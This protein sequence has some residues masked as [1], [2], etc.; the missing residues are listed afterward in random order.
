M[1][2][3]RRGRWGISLTLLALGIIAWFTLRPSPEDA[4]AA[5]RSSFTCLFP[6]GNESLRDIILNIILFVPFGLGLGLW[7][8]ALRAWLLSVLT[9]CTIE[10]VQYGWLLGRDASLRD[11]L[12]NS[13][14]GAIGVA[15]VSHWEGLLLPDLARSRRLAAAAFALWAVTTAAGAVLIRPVL[16]RSVY[17]GQWAPELGQFDRWQGT[18]REVEVGGVG[19]P[20]GRMTES[21]AFRERLLVDSVLVEATVITGPAPA[22]FAPIAS[23]FDSEQRE[24]FVLGQ[25]GRDLAFRIRTGFSAIELRGQIA[26]MREAFSGEPGDTIEVRGG[27]VNGEWVLGTRD[28]RGDREVRLPFSA[29]LAWSGLLP[30]PVPLDEQ[31]L[32]LSGLW[33]AGLLLPAGYWLGRATARAMPMVITV[34]GAALALELTTHLAGLPLPAWFEWAGV[35]LGPLVG[36]AVGRTTPRAIGPV[37]SHA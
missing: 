33:L 12:T 29:A 35:V 24:I 5:A 13:L 4:E 11:I 2:L 37:R 14:G 19:M 3:T 20:E 22:R 36:W 21:E 10:F 17:W 6:C 8:P 34:L 16:P 32:W 23:I 26:A 30:F 1:A 9:T 28:H 31:S 15:L 27:V 18:L 7:L 25:R